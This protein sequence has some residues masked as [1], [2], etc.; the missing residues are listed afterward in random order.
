ME[1]KTFLVLTDSEFDDLVKV[2][3]PSVNDFSFVADK[4]GSNDTAYSYYDMKKKDLDKYDQ[5]KV[6]EF[7]SQG[8]GEFMSYILFQ[9][10]VNRDILPE[11]NYLIEVNW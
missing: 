9:D 3:Y 4:E 7:N 1:V 6:D 2:N 8:Y 10:M 11:G 5:K